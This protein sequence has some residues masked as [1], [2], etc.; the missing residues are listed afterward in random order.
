MKKGFSIIELLIYTAVFS[1]VVITFITVF[2]VIIRIQNSQSASAEVETQSQYVLQQ[3]QYNIEQASLIDM[4]LDTPS[5]TLTLRMSSSSTD[6]TQITL[7]G[8]TLYLQ[9]TASGDPQALTSGQV[10]VSNLSF[11]RHDYNNAN[12]SVNISFT[13]SYNTANPQQAFSQIVRTSVAPLN[14]NGIKYLFEFGSSGTST[15]QFEGPTG[16]AINPS[17]NVYIA[18]TNFGTSTNRVEEFSASG[19]YLSGFTVTSS[20]SITGGLAMDG[21]GNFYVSDSG[22]QQ[23]DKFNASGTLISQFALSTPC[24]PSTSTFP[25]QITF[26]SSGNFYVADGKCQIQKFNTSGTVLSRFGGN[27]QGSGTGEANGSLNAPTGVAVDSA[28]NVYAA[29]IPY[30]TKFDSNG[31]FILRF[32]GTAQFNTAP[33]ELALDTNGNVYVSTY[34]S[35]AHTGIIQVFDSNGNYIRTFGTASSGYFGDPFGIGINSSGSI[36]VTDSNTDNVE[37]FGYP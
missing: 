14:E 37:V 22:H 33:N 31:N 26:D 25:E 7:S 24:G 5:T 19:T 1:I 35:I 15:G 30:V 29:D 6:P 21:S 32:G 34:N 27:T 3:M 12:D 16:V 20:K 17:G 23:I 2:V 13:I 10:I 18:D 11:T 9:Q 28:G 36:Y 8:G 4:P